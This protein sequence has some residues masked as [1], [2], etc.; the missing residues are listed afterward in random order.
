M[1]K[2]GRQRAREWARKPRA[3]TL[4][5]KAQAEVTKAVEKAIVA[6]LRPLLAENEHRLLRTLQPNE[7]EAMAVGA[8][9]AHLAALAATGKAD[10][11]NDDISDLF[12]A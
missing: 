5:D 2:A 11:L 7:V 10:L 3:P 12:V 4:D 8:I 1:Q 6:A 9:T